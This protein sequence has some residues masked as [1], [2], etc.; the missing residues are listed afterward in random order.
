A[1]FRSMDVGQTWE[2]LPGLRRHESAPLWQPGAGGMC[3]HTILLDPSH[4]GRI[5][6]AISAAGVFRSDDAGKTWRPMNR[7]LRSEQIPDPTAE[8]GHWLH[9]IAM[10]RTRP[11][12]LCMQKQWDGM[13]SATA[14]EQRRRAR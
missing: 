4:P 2:E 10:H 8:V 13:R 1:V 3:L 5:F 14:D 7:G 6:I 11:A 9:R 12:V